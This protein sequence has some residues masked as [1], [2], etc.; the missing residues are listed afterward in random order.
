MSPIIILKCICFKIILQLDLHGLIRRP[1]WEDGGIAPGDGGQLQRGAVPVG[2]LEFAPLVEHRTGY[3]IG[4]VS[5]AAVILAVVVVDNLERGQPA[6][7]L[8]PLEEQLV[9]VLFDLVLPAPDIDI[10]VFEG[11]HRHRGVL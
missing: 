11:V 7:D 5:D 2:E 4:D 8:L 9:R 1:S 3:R 10:V 6:Q